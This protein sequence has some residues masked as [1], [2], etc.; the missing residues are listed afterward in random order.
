MG[1]GWVGDRWVTGGG[2]Q[3]AGLW[4]GTLTHLSQRR[5]VYPGAQAS[6]VAWPSVSKKHDSENLWVTMMVTP[7]WRHQRLITRVG[8]HL[9][10]GSV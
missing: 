3:V 1:G 10:D 6:Q 9:R 4:E 2:A 5:P 7:G 8:T